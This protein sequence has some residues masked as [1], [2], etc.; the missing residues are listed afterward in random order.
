MKRIQNIDI[1]RGLVMV[2]MT[3]DHIRDFFHANPNTIEPTD[4]AHTSAALFLTRWI[5]HLCAPTFVF[6]S[7]VSAYI[8]KTQ[9][10]NFQANRIFLIKRGLWLIVLNFTINNFGIFFDIHFGVFFSQVIAVIGFGFLILAALLNLPAKTIGILGGIIILS[11]NLLQGISFPENQP[12][13]FI[14]TYLMRVGY[15]QLTTN[16]ALLISYA[17]I[18]WTGILLLGFGAG[19]IIYNSAKKPTL[20]SI[21]AYSLLAFIIVRFVNYYGDP[22]PWVVQNSSLMTILSFFNTTKQPPSL[23]F[24]LMT[25]GVAFLLLSY[26]SK[27][28]NVF[29]K[30]LII[31]GKVPLFYWLIH[32][33]FLHLIAIIYYLS[34]G[35][36]WSQLQ[37]TGFGF[38]RPLDNNG[39]PLWGVYVT[40]ILVILL[41]YPI[42]KWYSGYKMRN[43]NKQWLR[44]L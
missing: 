1:V 29:T 2:I 33:Y 38:G 30:W 42:T 39:M 22:S 34:Q 5:T 6:L 35:Y 32:W 28:E 9:Q 3:L 16:T 44:Y 11:H 31:F 18:P 40:W 23:L 4:L 12:L 21:G 24:V 20:L 25:L 15:F 19:E 37:F 26:F 10:K 14:W 17:I 8:S 41:L 43:K 27:R 13:N 36:K 7:G